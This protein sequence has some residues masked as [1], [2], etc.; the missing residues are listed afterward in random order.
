VGGHDDVQR[1]RLVQE[2][3]ELGA[4]PEALTLAARGVAGAV[5]ITLSER[6]RAG[7]APAAVKE[8]ALLREVLGACGGA[9][10]VASDPGLGRATVLRI[11][12]AER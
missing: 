8:P 2:R 4:P 11:P 10:H 5:L 7:V 12:L 3:I 6:Y 1:S 9:L